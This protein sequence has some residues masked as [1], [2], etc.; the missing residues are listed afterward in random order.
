MT[1]T[2]TVRCGAFLDDK[3]TAVRL[4]KQ[5]AWLTVIRWGQATVIDF[6]AQRVHD[7]IHNAS[8]YPPAEPGELPGELEN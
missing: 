3:Q 1:L 5:N 2:V 4:V 8:K 6:P 7:S